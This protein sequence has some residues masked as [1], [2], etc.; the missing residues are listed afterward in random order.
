MD[1]SSTSPAEAVAKAAKT[2]YDAS[3]LLDASERTK[4][5]VALKLALTE[6]KDEILAANALD[7]QV[8]RPGLDQLDPANH[9]CAFRGHRPLGCKSKPERCRRPS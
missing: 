5:L 1:H 8:S 4:A 3:Q 7:L 2:A 6:A 9:L